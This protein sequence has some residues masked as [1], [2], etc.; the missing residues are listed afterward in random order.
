MDRLKKKLLVIG[1]TGFIGS[2]LCEAAIKNN[3]K[4]TSLSLSKVK[5]KI[6]KVKYFRIDISKEKNFKKIFNYPY[7]YVV[8]LSGY[9]EHKFFFDGGEKVIINHFDSLRKIILN[10]NKKKLKKF[11]QVGS[12]DEYGLNL[13]P[14]VE[15]MREI[16]FSPY[17]FAKIASTHFL[18]MLNKTENF[19]C[20]ILRPFIVYGP[21]QKNDRFLPNLILSCLLNKKFPTSEGKQLRDYC[22]I[23]DIIDAILL[24]LKSNN[25][26][27]GEIFN[28]ASGKPIKI[29]DIIKKVRRK[30]GNGRPV[31]GKM[32]LRKNENYKLFSNNKKIYKAISWR[33]KINIDKG[34]D[35]TIDYYKKN[36]E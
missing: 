18:Q 10:L 35:I 1:G 30:I 17:S 27:N 7:D 21:K 19:P 26:Y 12:S 33:P 9:I 20:L 16:A 23:D 25:K 28:I 15:N 2:H 32:K 24:F 36:Y 5:N 14:Q 22:Y 13:A 8:N 31:I 11:I 4:V 6:K 29:I 3:Y 34:L